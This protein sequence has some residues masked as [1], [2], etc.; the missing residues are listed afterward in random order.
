MVYGILVPWPR[1]KLA[2]S[3]LQA[4]FLAPGP[5]AKSC[6]FIFNVYSKFMIVVVVVIESPSHVQL[7]ATPRTATRQTS[8][9]VTIS[10]MVWVHVHWVSDAIQ[11]PI[12]CHPLFFCLQSFPASGSFP[13]SWLFA[14]GGQNIGTS[15]SAPV[16]QWIFRIDFLLDWLA[17]SP[18]CPRDS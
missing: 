16:L 17:C 10:Q 15:A 5:P 1:I 9:S 6:F 14:S 13:R 11:P 18:C 2:S 7:F 8:L 12:L 4:G 3:V